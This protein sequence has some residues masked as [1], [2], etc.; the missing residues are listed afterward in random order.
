MPRISRI[1]I[2]GLPG[3]PQTLDLALGKVTA[4]VGP[5][6][7]GKTTVLNALATAVDLCRQATFDPTAKEKNPWLE[8]SSATITFVPTPGDGGLPTLGGGEAGNVELEYQSHA[9]W[10]YRLC[11]IKM[12]DREI[13]LQPTESEYTSNPETPKLQAE[14]QKTQQLIQLQE[15]NVQSLTQQVNSGRSQL[16]PQLQ[17]A[18]QQLETAKKQLVEVSARFEESKIALLRYVT[19]GDNSLSITSRTDLTNYLR[20]FCPDQLPV[21]PARAN[22]SKSIEELLTAAVRS[23]K[24]NDQDEYDRIRQDLSLLLQQDV[25][26][27]E[28]DKGKHLTVDGVDHL[29]V[30]SGT[31][32]CL[33]FYSLVFQAS[34]R[35]MLFWDEPENGIHSTRRFKLLELALTDTRQYVIA[36]HAPEL[37]PPMVESV[38]VYRLD[39]VVE[40]RT[41]PRNAKITFDIS[42]AK[43]RREAFEMAEAL[44]ITPSTT[45]F[46]S[47]VVIWVEGPSELY[48]WRSCLS[49]AGKKHHLIEGFDYTIMLYGGANIAHIEVADEIGNLV[50]FD[51]LALCRNPIV[52]VDSD[53]TE[54]PIGIPLTA[55]KPS[56]R[57]CEQQIMRINKDR[58]GAARF[59]FTKGREVENY[60]P[61][62]VIAR[63]VA[64]VGKFTAEEA[65]LLDGLSVGRWEH[66]FEAVNQ[67]LIKRGLQEAGRSHAKNH[68]LWG[69]ANK[70]N[71][72]RAAMADEEMGIDQLRY[73]GMLQVQEIVDWIVAKRAT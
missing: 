11:R 69:P 9:K 5:N 35:A 15:T 71:F 2:V 48:F 64:A 60:L 17:Q 47:N 55:L 66:Y 57:R 16:Q 49:E 24:G 67:H 37:A 26:A 28:D 27:S 8:F 70:V 61:E 29:L 62:P 72:V 39:S 31:Q 13:A 34:K 38:E 22:P 6:S 36:T 42:P 63:A 68:S 25:V 44:G 43:T 52:V 20:R 53:L 4:L 12:D 73:D 7:S 51:L 45:L 30:S 41:K 40:N 23:K 10:S 19:S 1:T 54:E 21:I 59:E 50:G 18:Q 46:T 3:I 58:P 33:Y 56:A 14:I 32:V 65:S